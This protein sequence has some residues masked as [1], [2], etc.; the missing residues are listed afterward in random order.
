MKKVSDFLSILDA[1]FF[2]VCLQ[3]R[4]NINVRDEL[5]IH[6]AKICLLWQ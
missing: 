3:F 6:D 1:K 4:L 5:H 2:K